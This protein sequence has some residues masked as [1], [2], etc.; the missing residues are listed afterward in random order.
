MNSTEIVFSW[1]QT[2]NCPSISY[3][4]LSRNCGNCPNSTNATS[5]SCFN[6]IVSESVTICMFWI[7]VA[8]CSHSATPIV[9]NP[10][11]STSLNLTGNL[12]YYLTSLH[13]LSVILVDVQ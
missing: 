9:G 3:N 4:I 5:V 13:T 8:I 11:N 6:Y 7:E 10:S 1:D 2:E 12:K